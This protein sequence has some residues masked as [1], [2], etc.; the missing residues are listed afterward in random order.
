MDSAAKLV[1]DSSNNLSK[2]VN[3][4]DNTLRLWIESFNKNVSV[5]QTTGVDVKKTATQEANKTSE[6]AT[7]YQEEAKGNKNGTTATT[8]TKKTS[9]TTSSSSSS[10]TKYST[11]DL[12]LEQAWEEQMDAMLYEGNG[13]AKVKTSSSNTSSNST[14]SGSSIKAWDESRKEYI[15]ISSQLAETLKKQKK[16]VYD[17]KNKRWVRKYAKGTKSARGGM[18]LVND[19]PGNKPELIVTDHGILLPLSPGD[20]V[21]PGDL[22]ENLMKIAQNGGLPMQ[23]PDIKMPDINTNQVVNSN[24]NIHFD[25]LI[26]VDGN[27]DETVLP[28]IEEIA[29]Q[30]TS[31][32]NFKQ[33]IYNFTSKEMAKDMRKAGY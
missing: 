18:S 16:L 1:S 17:D 28:S 11:E 25:S 24:A 22:T 33:N 19:G 6:K 9:S 5:N 14:S 21:I 13:A 31:N 8:S 2:S 32:K 3:Q 12:W 23:M 15:I 7:G 30:L 29:K 4:V 20:G 27:L 10:S 26:R